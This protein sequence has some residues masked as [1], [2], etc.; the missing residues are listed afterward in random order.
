MILHQN[1]SIL[2]RFQY[3]TSQKIELTRQFY[4]LSFFV[5]KILEFSIEE[6][7]LLTLVRVPTLF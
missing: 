4:V 1:F 7:K 2:I 6:K 3:E 5:R